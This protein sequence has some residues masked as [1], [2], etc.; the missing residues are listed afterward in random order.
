MR[1]M[2]SGQGRLRNTAGGF[3]QLVVVAA[4]GLSAPVEWAQA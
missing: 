3:R 2:T 1:L 4:I